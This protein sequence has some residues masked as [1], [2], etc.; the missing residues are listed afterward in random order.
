[1]TEPATNPSTE[2]ARRVVAGLLGMGVREVVLSP[3]SRNAPLSFAAYDAAAAGRLRLH[4]RLD[5]RTAGFL[6]LGLAKV[7]GAPAAVACTSGTAVA[8]LHPA[9]LEDACRVSTQRRPHF[10]Q[11]RGPRLD[12]MNGRGRVGPSRRGGQLHTAGAAT[13]HHHRVG[14]GDPP[15]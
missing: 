8:N 5:E 11:Q 13:H 2:L 9:L 4:T 14:L 15:P 12:Q 7:T 1:M 3:G 10:R 6:A